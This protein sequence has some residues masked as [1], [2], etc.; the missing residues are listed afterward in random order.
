[1]KNSIN[2]RQERGF[3]ATPSQGWSI[4]ARNLC[5]GRLPLKII[6]AFAVGIAIQALLFGILIMSSTFSEWAGQ[7]VVRALAREPIYIEEAPYAE[8][9][10]AMRSFAS[11][12]IPT[13]IYELLESPR[14]AHWAP[15]KMVEIRQKRTAISVA[16][17]LLFS[18]AGLS[19]FM[20]HSKRR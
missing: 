18:M 11:K 14:S 8:S 2:G 19:T 17:A 9:S 12:A 15:E 6:A 7:G 4:A 10:S 3:A 16:M 20:W 13:S 5:R 1:M